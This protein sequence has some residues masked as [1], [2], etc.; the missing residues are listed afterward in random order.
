MRLLQDMVTLDEALTLGVNALQIVKRAQRR[1]LAECLGYIAATDVVAQSPLPPFARSTMDGYCVRAADTHGA[2]EGIPAMLIRG[3]DVYPVLTGGAVADGTD[4]VV[5]LEYA[6]E[7]ED[8]TVLVQRPVASGENILA[9]GE[10]V[11]AGTIL[12]R[13]GEVLTSRSL[14]LLAAFGHSE[15]LVRDFRVLVLSSGNEIVRVTEDPGPGQ[16][17]DI[18]AYYLLALCRNMGLSAEYGGIVPD[19]M[20]QLSFALQAG[21]GQY[22]AVL[23]SGGSSAGALDYS[24][25]V[26]DAL[27]PP[28]VLAHGLMIRP[29]KPTIIASCGGKLIIGLPGHPLSCALTAHTVARPLLSHAAGRI[30]REPVFVQARLGRSVASAPGR[31]DHVPVIVVGSEA[32]PQL[33]KSAAISA[34]ARSNGLLTI[35]E[36]CEGL[37]TGETVSI[38]LWEE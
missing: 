9:V 11:P 18:N 24:R 8:G 31:R 14:A 35:N 4:A 5:M 26:I 7:L 20:A 38:E 6:E 17:R 36:T 3:V 32:F 23:I 28:G 15:V 27:G 22:D 12:S 30:W 13:A 1:P 16:V 10:D 37:S 25:A 19:D 33:S 2:G 34:L 21:V 29:G